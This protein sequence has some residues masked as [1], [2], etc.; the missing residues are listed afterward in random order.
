MVLPFYF[1]TFLPLTADN[2]L[3]QETAAHFCRLLVNDREGRVCTLSSYIRTRQATTSDSLTLEQLFC[4]YVFQHDGWQTLRI[5]PHSANGQV[6]WYAA[7]DALP[8]DLDP[9]HQKYIH[10]VFQR[11]VAEVEASHWETVDAYI[12]RMAQYQC[13]FGHDIHS[14]LHTTHST[15]IPWIAG[16]LFLLFLLIPVM[17]TKRPPVSLSYITKGKPY[18]KDYRN[19]GTRMP[20]G[21]GDSC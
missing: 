5:F 20:C 15:L 18:E 4:S 14:T 21:Q 3:P 11:L 1:F 7:I 10:E 8:G 16:M 9:E 19:R 6:S 13:R 2:T 12:D 17:M